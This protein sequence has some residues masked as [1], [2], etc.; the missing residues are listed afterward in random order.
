ELYAGRETIIKAV[1]DEL[2]NSIEPLIP[3]F[4]TGASGTGKSS[5]VQAGLVP[6]LE[7]HYQQR[8]Q[9]VRRAVFRPSGHPLALLADALKQFGL[10]L[11]DD[12]QINTLAQFSQFLQVNTSNQQVNLLVIDQFEEL[13]TP[14]VEPFLQ[15]EFLTILESL[16]P[17]TQLRTHVII[18]MRSD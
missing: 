6:T 1:C 17:F 2:V 9:I 12:E 7:A 3:L 4:I 18:T 10:K 13:F 8:D 11:S 5:F 15:Q 16:P 14:Q